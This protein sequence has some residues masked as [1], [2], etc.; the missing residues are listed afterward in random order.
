MPQRLAL[1]SQQLTFIPKERGKGPLSGKPI[2]EKKNLQGSVPVYQVCPL[3]IH[4]ANCFLRPFPP[5]PASSL[6]LAGLVPADTP[7][8]PAAAV[9]ARGGSFLGEV[10][11]NRVGGALAMLGHVGGNLK[12]VALLPGLTD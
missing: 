3:G 10:V 11:A 1:L 2:L 6:D 8:L 9:P 5:F 12:A 7:S 4:Q